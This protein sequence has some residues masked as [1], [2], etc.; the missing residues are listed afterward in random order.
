MDRLDDPLRLLRVID[1]PNTLIRAAQ[2]I[3]YAYGF[4]DRQGALEPL[5][6][7]VIKGE[8]VSGMRTFPST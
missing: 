1:N 3:S 4:L 7:Y 5:I 6:D 2:R 8:F